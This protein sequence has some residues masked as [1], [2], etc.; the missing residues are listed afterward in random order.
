[1]PSRRSTR[2]PA[3]IPADQHAIFFS[4]SFAKLIEVADHL[5]EQGKRAVLSLGRSAL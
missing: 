2:L 1:M 3:A 5:D 4:P